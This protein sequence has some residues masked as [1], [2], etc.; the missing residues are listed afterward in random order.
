LHALTPLDH[1][2]ALLLAVFFPIRSATFGYRRLAR[3]SESD[4]PRVRGQLYTQALLIQWGLSATVAALWLIRGRPWSAL[5]L[6]WRGTTGTLVTAVALA[7][8]VTGIGVQL[9]RMLADPETLERVRQRLGHIRRMLPE[10]RDELGRF[11]LLSFTAGVCEELLYRGFLFYY[12]RHFVSWP[13]AAAV[14]V[15]LFGLGH[16]YQGVRGVITTTIAGAVLMTMVLGSGSLYLAMLGHMLLDGYSGTM[17]R[18]AFAAARPAAA[19]GTPMAVPAPVYESPG[20]G[21][22]P[23]AA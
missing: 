4:V 15:V 20:P 1:L 13:I 18:I 11:Y 19:P 8:L 23:P 7:A 17:G 6:V 2:L 5:A 10:G 16:S 9:P 14:A 12:L 22:P 21:E 3:A